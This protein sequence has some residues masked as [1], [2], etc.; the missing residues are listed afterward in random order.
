MKKRKLGLLIGTIALLGVIIATL[1][2]WSKHLSPLTPGQYVSVMRS[3]EVRS[4]I[5]AARGAT[6]R[7]PTTTLATVGGTDHAF[8]LPHGTTAFG[9]KYLICSDEFAPYLERLPSYGYELEEQMGS[10]YH[11]RNAELGTLVHIMS[12]QWHGNMSLFYFVIMS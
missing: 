7:S 10:M 6:K 8:P 11:Y 4:V 12:Q 5:I 1:A 9:E 2:L 3:N